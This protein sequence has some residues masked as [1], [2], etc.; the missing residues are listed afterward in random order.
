[1]LFFTFT[2]LAA[3]PEKVAGIGTDPFCG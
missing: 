2:S 3:Q 1:M